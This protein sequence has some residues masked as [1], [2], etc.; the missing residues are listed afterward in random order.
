MK[1]LDVIIVGAG[2]AG[3]MAGFYLASAGLEVLILEKSTFPRRKVC[4]GGLT[5]RAFQEIP[6]DISSI[7][8]GRVNWGYLGFRGRK[9]STIKYQDPISYLI[10]RPSFD[11]FLLEKAAAQGCQCLQGQR[12]ISVSE[13]QGQINVKSQQGTYHSRYLMGADGIHSLVAKQIGLLPDRSISLAY[14][15]RLALPPG[16][17]HPLIESITFDFGTLPFGYGWIFPKRDHLNVGVFRSWPGKRTSKG[18]LLRFIRQHPVL[19]EVDPIE[20]RAYPGPQGG[21]K[22]ILHENNILLVGDAANLADP[23]L[24]EGLIY[25]LASGRMAAETILRHA[26]GHIEDLAAYT[27]QINK[28]YVR[29]FAYAKRL[30]LLVNALPFLNIQLLSASPTLQMMIIDLLR[31]EKSYHQ[32]WRELTTRFPGLIWDILRGK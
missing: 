30:S 18:D 29:Q 8:H 2:P 27:C 1:T 9:V 7:L 11:K 20:M 23:W 10:D 25:A 31:G 32:I 13:D 14:E 15:A 19:R 26:D 24:G 22:S 21:G 4:G 17:T 28:T 6:F 3:S 16:D 12:V 5:Q